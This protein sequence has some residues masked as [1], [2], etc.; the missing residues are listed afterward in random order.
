QRRPKSYR[1]EFLLGRTSPTE[2]TDGRIT[3]LD[4][5]PV[6][7]REEIEQAAHQ[8]VGRIKQRPPA[9]SALKVDGRRAYDL[10][11]AGE[12]VELAPREIDI[13]QLSIVEY[14]YPRLTLDVTCGSGTYIRSLGRDLAESLNTGAVMSGLVRTAIGPF[15]LEEA[16]SADDLDR[17]TLDDRLLPALMAVDNLPQIPLSEA[18]VVEISHGRSIL[19]PLDLPE[20]EQYAAITPQGKLGALLTLRQDRLG[21]VRVFLNK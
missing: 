1:G 3:E 20:A 14:D 9:Y 6:P 11:R 7:T 21:P 10:A 12:A 16:I 8:F 18:D 4:A 17:A 19:P 5:P 15:R 2:D 13:Y